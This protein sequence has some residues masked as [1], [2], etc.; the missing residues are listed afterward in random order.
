MFFP[1]QAKN[2]FNKA[3]PFLLLL[4]AAVS[5]GLQGWR[6]LFS[7]YAV[8]VVKVDGF[9]IGLI[10]SVREVPGLLSCVVGLFF[11]FFSRT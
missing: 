7:N 3:Y 2:N 1:K 9:W 4:T 10:E 8:H 6:T 11:V 5:V